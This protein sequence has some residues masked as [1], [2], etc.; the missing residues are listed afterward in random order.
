MIWD[1]N[2][3]YYINR[4]RWAE[5]S[6]LPRQRANLGNKYTVTQNI[7]SKLA[8][9]APRPLNSILCG[10]AYSKTASVVTWKKK[11][12][13]FHPAG[14]HIT[15]SQLQLGIDTLSVQGEKINWQISPLM[16]IIIIN[17]PMNRAQICSSH[18]AN[19]HF[20]HNSPVCPKPSLFSLPPF[21]SCTGLPLI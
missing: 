4:C 21:P 18:C 5:L 17:I 12:T 2:F 10:V 9:P 13:S 7:K 1:I 20:M 11:T 15:G 14:S 3:R 19:F 8:S 16:I 6:L